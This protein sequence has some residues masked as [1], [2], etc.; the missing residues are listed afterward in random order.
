MTRRTNEPAPLLEDLGSPDAREALAASNRAAEEW[1]RHHPVTLPQM[2]DFI[3]Q[4]RSAFG[5]EMPDRTP[6]SGDRI[7]ID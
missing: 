2:L 6:W 5:D 7:L 4:L 3:D 1:D